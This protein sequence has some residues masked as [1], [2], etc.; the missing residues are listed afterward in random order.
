[1]KT[2]QFKTGQIFGVLK[3]AEGSAPVKELCKKMA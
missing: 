1:M 2:K 3:E